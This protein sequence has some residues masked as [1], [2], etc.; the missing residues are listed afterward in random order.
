MQ[1]ALQNVSLPARM[2]PP[3]PL[4]DDE[5]IAFS[6]ANKMNDLAASGEV[7]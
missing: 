3:A 6:Q 1:L 5:L 7:S 2:R 4:S